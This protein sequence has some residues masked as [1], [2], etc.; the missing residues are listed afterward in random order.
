MAPIDRCDV[1]A[2]AGKEFTFMLV[3]RETGEPYDVNAKLNQDFNAG[4]CSGK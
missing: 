4:L 3:D 1:V 2:V